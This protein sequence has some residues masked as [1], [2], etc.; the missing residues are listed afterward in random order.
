MEKVFEPF[1]TGNVFKMRHGNVW[2]TF[3]MSPQLFYTVDHTAMEQLR[4][5]MELPGVRRVTLTPDMHGGY[6]F[7]IGSVIESETHIYPDVVGPDP[8]CSVA[9]SRI[10]GADIDT[11][12]EKRELLRRVQEHIKVGNDSN[13]SR[14]TADTLK[15]VMRGDMRIKKTWVNSVEPLWHEIGN[16]E[17]KELMRLVDT[18]LTERML[19][20]LGTIGGGNHFWE[21]QRDDEGNTYVMTHFG[22]RGIGAALA[23]YFDEA[24]SAELKKWGVN[25]PSNGLI[26]IPADSFLGRVYYM[27]QIAML[28]WATFNHYYVHDLTNTIIQ[29]MYP[30]ATMEFEGHIPHNF[31][32]YRNGAYV[33]RKG[34]TPAYEFDGIPLLIPGSMSTASYV[35]RPGAKSG[36]LG[37]SVA[38]GAG[39][40]LTRGKAKELLSQEEVNKS[41]TAAGVIGN[42]ND[43]PLDESEGAYK[44]VDEV[45]QSL[46]DCGAAAIERKLNPIMVLKG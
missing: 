22:S 16:P 23:K 41:F 38:H 19:T 3:L 2:A 8:A 28:E 36:E 46:V 24:I 40:V 9:L 26:Y 5:T 29:S 17:Y 39:R 7:P 44:N 21:L 18:H 42:F 13:G 1:Q 15:H 27:F 33:G 4:A 45:I 37:E 30:N 35:L 20:Q 11:E 34:A 6:G 25:V 32:E 43:V 12:T 31:I 14:M 10:T